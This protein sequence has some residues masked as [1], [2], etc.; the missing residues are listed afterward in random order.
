MILMLA[1]LAI[2]M[3]THVFTTMRE[4][5]GDLMVSLGEI[6]Y[7]ALYSIVALFGFILIVKGYGDYRAAGMI[8]VWDPP[9]ALRHLVL[10]LMWPS[11]IFLV[12]S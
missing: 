5:R 10:L 7:K 1:G 11:F 2:F 9:R 8:P 12:A 4:R 3:A 6:R